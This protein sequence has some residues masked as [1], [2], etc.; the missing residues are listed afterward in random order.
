MTNDSKINEVVAA[1]TA[2]TDTITDWQQLVA[3]IVPKATDC[4][5]VYELP[6][7]LNR[8]NESFAIADMREL[9][10]TGPHYHANGEIEIY[11]VLTGI[12]KVFVG[13]G[14]DELGPGS[15]SVTPPNTVHFTVPVENLVLA[16]VNTPPFS[17]EN[18]ISIMETDASVGFDK[19]QFEALKQSATAA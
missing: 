1:W 2:Y 18:A 13:G 16:V 8:P 9:R 15:G 5:P 12:G 19:S 3:G 10:I 11:I 4:G 14:E 6:N 17:P 7:P